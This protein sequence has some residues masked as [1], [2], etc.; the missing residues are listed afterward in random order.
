M[1]AGF[2]LAV[3]VI[4]SLACPESRAEA[5]RGTPPAFT[6]R[7]LTPIPNPQAITRTVWLPAL[8]E[9]YVPQGIVFLDGKLFVSG[10]RSTDRKQD[11][12]PCRVFAMDAAS[13]AILGHLD[14]PASCG[15]AGG[16]AKGQN[17]RLLVTDASVLFEIEFIA[18]GASY[19]GRLLRSVKL[20]NGVKGSFAASEADGFWTGEYAR[21]ENGRLYKFRWAALAKPELKPE[22]AIETI[23]APIYSQGAAIDNDGILWVMRSGSRFGELVKLERKSG[24]IVAR[25]EMPAGAEGVSFEADGSLWTLS[26]SGSRRWSEWKSFYPLAFR[27]DPARLQASRARCPSGAPVTLEGEIIIP[28]V[29]DGGEWFWPGKFAASPCE[30]TTLRGKGELPPA[31]KVGKRMAVTGNV[32]EEGVLTL[33]VT[34]IRCY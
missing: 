24:A 30:V 28:P 15:H 32:A 12:G 3:A 5:P 17:G 25:Y 1:R 27:Y 20:R 26:E 18:A 19:R 33:F 4:V 2:V 8:D 6:A 9:G 13:G 10:Y 7:K 31:C 29:I 22:D 23:A 11:R 21:N 16:L 14:L 34:E